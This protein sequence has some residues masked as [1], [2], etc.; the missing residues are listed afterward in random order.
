MGYNIICDGNLI[1]QFVNENDRDR[2]FDMLSDF[3]S[4]C[5]FTKEDIE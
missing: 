4:D 5:E 3:Y 1:A 2:C